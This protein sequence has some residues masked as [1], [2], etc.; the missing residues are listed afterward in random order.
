[1][2]MIEGLAA[3]GILGATLRE[4]MDGISEYRK[5]QLLD[6]PDGDLCLG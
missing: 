1:M 5:T 2:A 3:A 4:W 6:Y